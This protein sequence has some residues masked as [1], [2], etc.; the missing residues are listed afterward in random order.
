MHVLGHTFPAHII[1]YSLHARAI[2]KWPCEAVN[3]RLLSEVT[4]FCYKTHG[5]DE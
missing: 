4:V 1:S 5:E 2:Q 3:S